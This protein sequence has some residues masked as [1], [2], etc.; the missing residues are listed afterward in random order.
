MQRRQFMRVAGGGMV[1]AAVAGAGLSGCAG[2]DM[3]AGAV[4]AWQPPASGLELRQWVLSHA[5]LAPNPH[6]RQPWLADL[7]VPGEIT[8]RLDT[9]RLLPAT[10]PFSRQIMMGAGAFLELL[11][12][13]AA[14]RGH[15]AD[16]QLFPEGEPGPQLQAFAALPFAR[17]RL[18]PDAAARPD[19][20]FAQLF[21][22]RTDRR[23]YDPL[24]APTPD[25]VASLRAAALAQPVGFG[26]AGLEPGSLRPAIQTIAR[27]AWRLELTTEATMM[28]SMHLL[29]VGAA[30]V[31]QHRDGI[32]IMSPLLITVDKLGLMDRQRMPAADSRMIVSQIDDFNALT[33]ST[34]AYL[35][36][37]TDGPGRAPQ[38]AA[39]RAYAR[40]NLAGTA[41]GLAMQPNEQALQEY[42]EVAAPYR[43]IHQLLAAGTP[44]R[45]VQML[46]RVGHLPAGTAALGPAPR[47][48]LARQLAAN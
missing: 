3:P 30:E 21:K 43:A 39:G 14:A 25:E 17:V 33:A 29:R 5:L 12:M 34:P 48:G 22:R 13:A 20:L 11:V 45:T 19:P 9:Q 40:V 16:V 4:A 2:A 47:R 28:E 27:D 46:A 6:N 38:I 26:L 37:T 44:G 10:D 8:L 1:M 24:A 42:P 41:L 36:I 23:A 32:S 7:A 31:D 35:W 15:R 18:V